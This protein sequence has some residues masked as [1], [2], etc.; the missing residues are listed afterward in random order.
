MFP[1]LFSNEYSLI[2]RKRTHNMTVPP[3]LL[4]H[5]STEHYTPQ[6]ILDAV[7]ACMGVIDVD[8]CS[9]SHEIPNVP[10]ARHYT[11]HDNGF[12]QPWEGRVF[13]NPPFGLGGAVVQQIVLG[14]AF[15]LNNGSDRALEVSDRD[16][17]LEYAD[18]VVMPGVFSFC[19]NPVCWLAGE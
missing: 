1:V 3:A 10:A 5:E 19:E 15:K 4:S 6:Y 8:P 7:I 11:V 14:E 12:V 9:K 16:S 2:L 18:P 13:I 17:S